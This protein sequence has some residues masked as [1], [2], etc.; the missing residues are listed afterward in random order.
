MQPSANPRLSDLG[1]DTFT[2]HWRRRSFLRG[3]LLLAG[4]ASTGLL[5]ACQP[6]ATTATVST[7]P[8]LMRVL[9]R[10]QP[11]VLPDVAPLVSAKTVAIEKNIVAMLALMDPQILKDIDG[12][13]A[14]FEYGSTVLGWHFASFSSL[15]ESQA[16]EYVERW[17][18]G[19][20][21]QRAIVTV[22]KK[23]IYASYWR[24]PSTWSAV[25]F[26]GPVAEKW[27]LPS[28]GN[29]PLPADVNAAVKEAV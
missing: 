16:L 18:N 2:T 6:A 15:D 10:M 14:L 27:G 5:T 20:G 11:I 12:A 23:M 1:L 29:A 24:D 9:T 26:D 13:A 28:L 4:A 25:G 7:A 3:S 21:M 19:V 17:Q 8:M 22:F